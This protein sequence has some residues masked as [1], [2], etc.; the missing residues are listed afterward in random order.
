MRS[1]TRIYEYDNFSPIPVLAGDVLGVFQPGNGISQLGVW[2]EIDSG[3]LTYYLPTD[4]M[5][6]ESPYVSIDLPAMGSLSSQTYHPLVTVQ[7]SE[8]Q[9]LHRYLNFVG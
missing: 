9:V 8:L 2:S 7:M 6:T 5:T 3:S 1:S 4:N